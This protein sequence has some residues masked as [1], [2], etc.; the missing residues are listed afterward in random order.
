MTYHILK[1][2]WRGSSS[3]FFTLKYDILA[4]NCGVVTLSYSGNLTPPGFSPRQ[5]YFFVNFSTRM[6]S[7]SIQMTYHILKS[8]WSASSS[9]FFTLKYDIFAGNC[10]VVRSSYSGNL[11]TAGFS[12]R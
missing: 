4:R 7:C 3:N 10:P 8:I 5:K 12:P 6:H 11:T 9:N 2:I 1:S